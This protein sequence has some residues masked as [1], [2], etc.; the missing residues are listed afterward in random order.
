[1]ISERMTSS[2][3]IPPAFL[4]M[5]ASPVFNPSTS[6]TVNRA[7]MQARTAIFLEGGI[8][9]FSCLKS[10][11]YSSFATVSYSIQPWGTL[12]RKEEYKQNQICNTGTKGVVCAYSIV[13][14][15]EFGI[16]WGSENLELPDYEEIE[17]PI[18]L[19]HI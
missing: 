9:R 12:I 5:W 19:F 16:S 18:R 11:E 14:A 4:I 3:A 15:L 13:R 8:G 6:S 1:M 10:L 7:S 2:V 17:A